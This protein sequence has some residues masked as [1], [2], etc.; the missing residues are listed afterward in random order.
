MALFIMLFNISLDNQ[1]LLL[2]ASV[3]FLSFAIA[4]I[5]GAVISNS[6]SLFGDAAAMSVDVS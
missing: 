3:L 1:H 5:I 4:E 6:L 2:T